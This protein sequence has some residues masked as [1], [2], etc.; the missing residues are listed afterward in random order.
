MG[1]S[2][3]QSKEYL[4]ANLDCKRPLKSK[5]RQILLVWLPIKT[6]VSCTLKLSQTLWLFISGTCFL[7]YSTANVQLRLNQNGSL[8]DNRRVL[9]LCH[10]EWVL[11]LYHDGDSEQGIAREVRGSQSYVD[12]IIKRCN[13]AN[14]SLRAPEVCCDPTKV[15]LYASEY[16]EAQQLI[17]PSISVSG[18]R[19][20]LLLDG[21]L[22]PTDL[23]SSQQINVHEMNT[24]RREK[25][26]QL[27][28]VNLPQLK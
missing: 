3:F 10:C 2:D 18:I 25:K 6:L 23:P 17:K 11:D 24:W 8:H 16:I 13:E 7:L 20:R 14:T 26:Y 19:Q 27:F 28:R 4:G 22:H 9:S 15:D 12:N 21:V 1:Q 5:H